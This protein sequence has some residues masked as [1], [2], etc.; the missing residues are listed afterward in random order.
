MNAQP[1][2]P[3]FPPSEPCRTGML[4]V[5][6]L[7]ALYWEESGNPDGIPVVY[8]HGGPGTGASP[9]QRRWFNPA[10]YRIVL[11]DQRGA[12]RSTPLGECRANATGLLVQDMEA[13]RGMLGIDRW[14]VAGGSWGTLLALAYG[15]AFPDAC[16]GFVL[17]GV[18]LGSIREIDWY[19]HGM[20]L[21]YPKAH[22]SFT[23]WIPEQ[24]K[25]DVLAAYEKRLFA[26]APAIRMDIAR[27]W[28]QYSEDCSLLRHDPETV[29]ASLKNAAVVYST[30]RL[31]AFYFR[32]RMFLEPEQLM[33]GMDSIA[34]LPAMIVQG[35]HDVITPPE[36]AYRLH[37][38]WPGSVMQVVPDAGHSPTEPGTRARLIQALEQFR[39]ERQFA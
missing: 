28:Y 15:Q 13:L 37:Q 38:A 16:L 9:E 6:D 3:L 31:H 35:G 18:L 20:R 10:H 22:D 5:D 39:E 7:H 23:A 12:F 11:F 19:L 27:R 26:D 36:T 32:N 14:L 21:F 30:A 33:R 25:E 1:D 8:V 24:E 17:R 29:E 34:H 2:F 4:A